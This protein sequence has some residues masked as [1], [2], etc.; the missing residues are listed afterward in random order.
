MGPLEV[1]KLE[2]VE[3]LFPSAVFRE[4]GQSGV[5]SVGIGADVRPSGAHTEGGAELV[6]DAG[7][8]K[9]LLPG[10]A[11]I[12]PP[13][14]DLKV[15]PPGAVAEGMV[16]HVVKPEVAVGIGQPVSGQT[17]GGQKKSGQKRQEQTVKT[18]GHG[19]GR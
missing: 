8:H 5:L 19:D 10:I 13:V 15:Q 7:A 16:P 18:V 4:G 17:G 2:L 14:L 12:G 11:E 3:D 1:Q 6:V 9:E